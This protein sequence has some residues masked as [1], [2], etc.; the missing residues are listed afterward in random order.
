MPLYAND[1]EKISFVIED[2]GKEIRLKEQVTYRSHAVIGSL[3]KPFIL[4]DTGT[5]FNVFPNPFDNELIINFTVER[6]TV[7]HIELLSLTGRLLYSQSYTAAHPGNHHI[8]IGNAV[9]GNLTAGL[10]LVRIKQPNNESV[11][12]KVIKQ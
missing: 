12:F 5:Q 2:N 11:T 9:T 4:S 10:Y 1:N 8:V 7:L 6:P 3:S